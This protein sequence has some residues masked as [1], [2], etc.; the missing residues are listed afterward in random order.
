MIPV[1]D[2]NSA[3]RVNKPWG[4]E[5]WIECDPSTPYAMKIIQINAGCRLSLQAHAE[6]METMLILE[7]EGFLSTSRELLDTARWAA[8]QYSD[9]DRFFLFGSI[10]EVP[11]SAGSMMTIRPGQIHRLNATTDM[12]LVECSTNHLTDVVRIVDDYS[13]PSGHIQS[14]HG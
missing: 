3:K 12:R 4:Y 14:E 2:I 13:R 5:L 8:N 10:R 7:G 9:T 6:K 1:H 11:I